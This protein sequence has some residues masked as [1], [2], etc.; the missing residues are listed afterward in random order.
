MSRKKKQQKDRDKE[1]DAEQSKVLHNVGHEL[2]ELKK[3]EAEEER[4]EKAEKE[5][6][7]KSHQHQHHPP[8]P[9]PKHK[10]MITLK[11]V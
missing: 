8:P 2:T 3:L 9:C 6:L 1:I 11:I 7:E 4:R 10:R 5:R